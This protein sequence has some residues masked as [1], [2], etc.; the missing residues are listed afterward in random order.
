MNRKEKRQFINDRKYF[1]IS[2]KSRWPSQKL[3]KSN[4]QGTTVCCC[5]QFL[6]RNKKILTS[7]I[8]AINENFDLAIT[9]RGIDRTHHIWNP[10]NIGEKP[11]PIIIK[12]VRYNNRKRMFDSMKKLMGK[13]IAITEGMTFTDMNKLNEARKS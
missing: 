10:R 9:D 3:W 1:Y 6:K 12:L 4:I 8:K 2:T 13:K 7:C 5:M 11:R